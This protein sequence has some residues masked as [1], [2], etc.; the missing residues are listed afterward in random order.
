[1][2]EIAETQWGFFALV[3]YVPDPLGSVLD[4]LRQTVST[5]R[6]TRAHITVLPPRPLTE[7]F[8]S[9]CA[10]VRGILRS[11]PPFEVE[12]LH[13]RR[14]ARYLYLDLGEGSLPVRELHAALNTGKLA[15]AEE[16]P[17]LPH[18]TVGGPFARDMI[19]SAQATAEQAWLSTDC[20]RR[21]TLDQVVCLWSDRGNSPAGWTRLGTYTLK[22]SAAAAS[23]TNRTS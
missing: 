7:P 17:F 4:D 23:V 10:R 3:S 11:F 9:A 22:A 18:L 13:V 15:H 12:L 2:D 19:S 21:F 6:E 20:P 14:F 8:E 5:D 1:M 16:F